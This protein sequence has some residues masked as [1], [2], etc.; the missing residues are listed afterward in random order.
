VG[1]TRLS[2]RGRYNAAV[3]GH[4]KFRVVVG[5]LVGPTTFVR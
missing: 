4:G 3:K 5:D 2:K 1:H